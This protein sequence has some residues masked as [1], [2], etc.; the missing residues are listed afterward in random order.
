MGAIVSDFKSLPADDDPNRQKAYAG[1][2]EDLEALGLDRPATASDVITRAAL[3]A[4][5]QAQAGAIIKAELAADPEGLY[6]GGPTNAQLAQRLV[7]DYQPANAAIRLPGSHDTGYRIVAGSTTTGLVAVKNPE[8]TDPGFTTIERLRAGGVRFRQTA[9]DP[10]LR[11][12]VMTIRFVASDNTLTL[13][14]ALPGAP[15]V[16][17]VFDIGILRPARLNGRL[18]QL[19]RRLPYAPNVLT[20]ADVAG[21]KV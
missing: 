9:A 14:A 4:H 16:G 5:L 11:G 1:V 7:Q 13:D 6:T 17:D 8:L 20:A 19:L 2:Y 21:A 18:N 15:A 10:A 3:L 12:A